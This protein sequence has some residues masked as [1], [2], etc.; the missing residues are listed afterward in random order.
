MLCLEG[1]LSLFIR[2]TVSS[3]GGAKCKSSHLRGNLQL[4]CIYQ[5]KWEFSV[6]IG[7]QTH[8]HTAF[9][10]RRRYSL[11]SKRAGRT[12]AVQTQLLR[13]RPDNL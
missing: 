13:N 2:F 8:L 3:V 10:T 6:R 11:Y 5:H 1:V 12:L 9:T 4:I 7:L